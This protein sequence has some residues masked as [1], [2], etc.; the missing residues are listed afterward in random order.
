MD[1]SMDGSMNGSMDG[2]VDGLKERRTDRRTIERAETVMHGRIYLSLYNPKPIP[3]IIGMKGWMDFERSMV[4]WIDR[5][6]DLSIVDR[7]INRSM[8]RSI[9]R[10]WRCG[11]AD[12][13]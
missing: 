5:T 4:R 6:I 1:G 3:I 8:D 10:G 9:N 12:L 13:V 7:S 2:W 11:L